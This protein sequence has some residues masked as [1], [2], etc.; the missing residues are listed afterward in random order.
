MLTDV[1]LTNS[2]W[3][4]YVYFDTENPLY[5]ILMSKAQCQTLN[6]EYHI[7]HTQAHVEWDV[8][9]CPTKH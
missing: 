8:E 3:L 2:E 6:I 9:K 4:L 7:L 5:H 1:R